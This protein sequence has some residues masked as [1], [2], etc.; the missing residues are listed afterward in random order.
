MEMHSVWMHGVNTF[1]CICVPGFT[2]EFCQTKIDDS[3]SGSGGLGVNCSVNREC[4][5]MNGVSHCEC[6][7]GRHTVCTITGTTIAIVDIC[8]CYMHVYVICNSY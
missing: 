2:G 7:P 1:E 5:S 8:Y 6:S 4:L 3:F